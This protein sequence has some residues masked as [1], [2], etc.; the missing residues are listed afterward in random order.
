LTRWALGITGLA[1]VLGV[2]LELAGVHSDARTVVVLLFLATGPT[3]AIA[4][5]LRTVDVLARLVIAFTADIAILTLTAMIMLTEGV[6]SPTGG[7]LAVV[8][9]TAACAIVQLPPVRQRLVAKA[10]SWR[11]AIDGPVVLSNGDV[12]TVRDGPF[13][14][15]LSGIRVRTDWATRFLYH[16]DG[17]LQGAPS[18]S[19][20]GVV[21]G[22]HVRQRGRSMAAVA[23]EDKVTERREKAFLELS[24]TPSSWSPVEPSVIGRIFRGEAEPTHPSVFTRDDGTALLY[25]RRINLFAGESESCKT[26]ASLVAV[27]QEVRKGNVACIVDFEDTAETAIDRLRQLGL[28]ETQISRG[29]VCCSPDSPF[30][31]VAQAH[32]ERHLGNLCNASNRRLTLAVVDSVNEA[33][34]VEGV[35]P[36][37]GGD[38]VRFC[39]GL[40]RWL[41]DRGPAVLLIEHVAKPGDSRGRTGILSEQ[42]M[43]GVDGAAYSFAELSPFGRGVAGR[44]KVTLSKDRGGFVRQ[45]APGRIMGT[46]T[47]TS[48]SQDGSVTSSFAPPPGRRSASRRAPSKT[49]D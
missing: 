22:F 3:A 20:V 4:G 7:L 11:M 19:T 39:H 8:G 26:W 5:M 24:S 43:I 14:R 42:T 44:V 36:E 6:W 28:S 12:I 27:A 25:P 46:L 2:G 34:L 29:V 9:V 13:D 48:S 37:E 32:L 16:Q 10:S 31:I 35:D 30:D 45:H 38:V 40:P 33:M 49:S 23:N 21:G 1:G 15:F 41:R 47:L 17:D 18:S